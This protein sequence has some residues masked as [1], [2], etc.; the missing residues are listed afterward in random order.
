VLLYQQGKAN[1]VRE[2]QSMYIG[3]SAAHARNVWMRG[4]RQARA[5]TYVP[6]SFRPFAE[7]LASTCVR[8]VC[9]STYV[10]DTGM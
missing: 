2:S 5:R 7:N 4:S 3:S 1:A 8:L 9:C 6:T 10:G